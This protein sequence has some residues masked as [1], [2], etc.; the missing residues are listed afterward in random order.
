MTHKSMLVETRA[1]TYGG[2]PIHTS[3][4]RTVSIR[5]TETVSVDVQL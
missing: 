5:V 2:E 1:Y 3:D 4:G